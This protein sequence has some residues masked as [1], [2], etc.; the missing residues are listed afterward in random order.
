MRNLV[1]AALGMLTLTACSPLT[2]SHPLFSASDQTGPAPVAEGVWVAIDGD[3]TREAAATTPLPSACQPF[4]LRRNAAGA[5]EAV[6][7][8]D[9]R[10]ERLP[11]VLAPA[12]PRADASAYAPLYL[13]QMSARDAGVDHEA[14]VAQQVY[15]IV[16]PLGPMPA[17]EVMFGQ[18]EC[19]ALVEDWPLA[20]I[21]AQRD[22]RGSLNGCTVDDPATALEAARRAT[23]AQLSNLEQSRMIFVHQ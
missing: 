15:G 23:I 4:D 6:G 19:D 1:I 20:G 21:T 16:I 12:F 22:A 11:F 14:P 17:H 5:W 8:K 2:S 13:V 7:H 9:G 18:I 10:E 3:C